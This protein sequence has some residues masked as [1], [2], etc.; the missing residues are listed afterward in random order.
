[1]KKLLTVGLSAVFLLAACSGETGD[2]TTAEQAAPNSEVKSGL[3][4]FY[5]STAQALNA[6]DAELNTYEA[7]QAE[8]TLP[9]GEE[10]QAMK[11]AAIASAEKTAEA[12]AVI[13]IPEV[14][15]EHREALAQSLAAIEES[16][17]MK[18]ASLSKPEVSFEEANAKFQEAD[19]TFNTLLK[20][21]G[22]AASSLLNEVSK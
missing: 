19:E 21:Q 18:A 14:L 20:E 15:A 3:M 9:E 5:L 13:E 4:K 10:L 22:L 7:S 12:A 11:D 6:T 16:Y 2:A 8:G 17:T 1:M